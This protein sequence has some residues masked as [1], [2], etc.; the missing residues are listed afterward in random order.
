MNIPKEK[1]L[2][3]NIFYMIELFGLALEKLKGRT[4]QEKYE[5]MDKLASKLINYDSIVEGLEGLAR[6]QNTND[7]AIFLFDLIER[8][9]DYGL[10]VVYN[11]LPELASDFVD[12]Y[13]LLLEEEPNLQAIRRVVG[14]AA[15]E[16]EEISFNDFYRQEL[17]KSIDK[18]FEN[19]Q[20]KKL[21]GIIL[22]QAQGKGAQKVDERFKPLVE[23]ASHITVNGQPH[24]SQ[25]DKLDEQLKKLRGQ[26]SD[27]NKQ[28]PDLI[29]AARESASLAPVKSE[30]TEKSKTSIDSLLQEYFQSEVDEWLA[31]VGRFLD[32]PLSDLNREEQLKQLVGFFK[33]LKEVS[34]IHGYTGLELVAHHLANA[35]REKV[36]DEAVLNESALGQLRTIFDEIRHTENFSKENSTQENLERLKLKISSFAES[37]SGA[38]EALPETAEAALPEEPAVQEEPQEQAAEEGDEAAAEEEQEAEAQEELFAAGDESFDEVLAGFLADIARNPQQRDLASW[39]DVLDSNSIFFDEQ[40]ISHFTVPMRRLAEVLADAEEPEIYES[41]INEIWQKLADGYPAVLEDGLK[42]S[43]SALIQRVL[44]DAGHSFEAEEARKAL[45]ET[46][47]TLLQKNESALQKGFRGEAT[48]EALDF[49]RHIEVNLATMGYTGYGNALAFFSENLNRAAQ[50]PFDQEIAAE[51]VS[52]FRLLCDRI[53]YQGATGNGDDIVEV[54]GEVL[55]DAGQPAEQAEEPVEEEVQQSEAAEEAEEAVGEEVVAE[56]TEEKEEAI[57]E[58]EDDRALFRQEATE[59]LQTFQQSIDAFAETGDRFELEKIENACHSIRSGAHLLNLSNISRLAASIEDIAELFGQSDLPLPDELSADLREA[60]ELLRKSVDEENVNVQHMVER[61]DAWLDKAMLEETAKSAEADKPFEIGKEGREKAGDKQ[62]RPEEK[63][64]FAGEEEDE[65]LLEIFREESANFITTLQEANRVLLDDSTNEDAIKN[66]SYA[67]HSLKSASKMLGFTDVTQIADKLEMLGDG[68]ET[69]SMFFSGDVHDAVADALDVLQQLSTGREIDAEQIAQISESL[70][71]ASFSAQ[72][73]EDQEQGVESPPEDE[74]ELPENMLEIFVDEAKE[75]LS[76]LDKDYL[77]LEKMPESEMLLANILRR[78]HTLKG[79]AYISKF[80]RLGDLAHKLEDY[81]QLFKQSESSR[82]NEML[83]PVFSAVDLMSDMV[84]SIAAGDGEE[85][86]NYTARLAEIDNKMFLYQD[87]GEATQ[88]VAESSA[89]TSAPKPAKQRRS[90]DENILR[91]NT[92]YMDKLVDMASELMINQSQ[93]GNHLQA[94][95]EMLSEIEGEKKQIRGADSAI[96]DALEYS[97]RKTIEEAEKPGREQDVKKLSQNIRD[98]V[99]TVDLIHS[100]LNKITESF[101]QNI[102]RIGSLSKILHNDILKTRMVPVENLFNRYPRAVR[103]MSKEQKKKV[104]LII[105]DNNTEMDRAMVEGLSEPILH[106]IRNAIDHGLELPEERK[107]NKKAETGTLV[108]KAH[109]DKNQ[110]V[111][112]IEDDGCGID[113]ESVKQKAIEQNLADPQEIDNLSEAEI[114]DFIFYP[115]F[116]TRD[117]ASSVSGRGIGLDAVAN[118]L[119]KLKGNIRVKTE[120][121]VGTTFSLRVP[122][123]LVI[124]QALMVK[125]NFQTI[126]IPVIAVQE[127]VQYKSAEI[128]EDGGKK[129]IR[130]RGRL[131]PFVF[132]GDLLRFGEDTPQAEFEERMAIVIYDAGVSMA[133]GV[134][135]IIGRREIVIKSLGSHLQ[136][137]DYV[138]GGTIMANGEVALILDYALVIRTVEK[139]FF[140]KVAERLSS[141]KSSVAPVA[142]APE[143][144]KPAKE[145]KAGRGE[146]AAGKREISDRKPAIL[147]VDDS[148]SVRNFV[149]SILERNGFTTIKSTNGEEA[150]KKISEETVDLVIT[151][152]EMPKMHGFELIGSIRSQEKYKNLPIIILTGRAGMKHRQAGTDLGA[153]DFLVKPFKEKDLLNAITEFIETGR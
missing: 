126:A 105:E 5:L 130:V 31:D 114:L 1:A 60:Y 96:E 52:S 58:E 146:A 143:T 109:Q 8:A 66:L 4:D 45:H 41:E 14:V 142:Q 139:H 11:S 83:D 110:I 39:L 88:E 63:P 71:P 23:N 56:S 2:S 136:N 81:L 140:G 150:L 89:A 49:V 149:G 54:L 29:K 137:V 3:F 12:L 125:V 55:G 95:K 78:T 153:N 57:S 73:V 134:D 34:M 6:E 46:I 38:G 32:R 20:D 100:D 69:K 10:K 27:L 42:D 21:V 43:I 133:L 129:Y 101:E 127:S 138:A 62:A 141:R 119:Q 132:L 51:F 37:M 79:S 33:N 7:L 87:M 98:V 28:E 107:K 112:N 86:D 72:P 50:S 68:L 82:K 135:E 145:K 17:E 106:I 59:H 111:I 123:T 13:V 85:V 24:A 47:R 30:K 99:R 70:D 76:G 151:D 108:L 131:L 115:G 103:D 22:D 77:E 18:H 104:N 19:D 35:A 94:L 53:S 91:I 15:E 84:D 44:D 25:Y 144:E 116:S 148:N 118:Q 48:D 9:N 117:E 16:A 36:D 120:K 102:S 121:N 113:I 26:I 122:L 92:E 75:L 152:L 128:V 74:D 40:L 65:E 80:T 61:M 64:L 67:A 93:L 124:S 97:L 90:D 147:I